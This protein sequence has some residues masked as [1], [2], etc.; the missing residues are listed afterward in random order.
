SALTPGDSRIYA[1]ASFF[2]V[3]SKSWIKGSNIKPFLSSTGTLT[4]SLYWRSERGDTEMPKGRHRDAKGETQRCRRGDTEMPKGR[5]RDAVLKKEGIDD[6]KDLYKSAGISSKVALSPRL[7]LFPTPFIASGSRV[8]LFLHVPHV[9]VLQQFCCR[10][11]RSAQICS[12]EAVHV[13]PL[14]SKLNQPNC[15]LITVPV[16]FERYRVLPCTTA[17]IGSVSFFYG[18]LGGQW[19]LILLF[20]RFFKSVSNLWEM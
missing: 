4:A 7:F 10:R 1:S 6:G 14:P 2:E 5:H 17:F 9:E 13:L 8:L 3:A 19:G 20:G 18:G 12:S 16:E 15:M 11:P